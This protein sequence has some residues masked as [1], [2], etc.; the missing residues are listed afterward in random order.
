M[1]ELGPKTYLNYIECHT[2]EQGNLIFKV[3]VGMDE[4]QEFIFRFVW[5]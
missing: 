1:T 3:P 4:Y 2:D 5:R